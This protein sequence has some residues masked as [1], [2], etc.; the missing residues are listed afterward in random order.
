MLINAMMVAHIAHAV[1]MYH[2]RNCGD[3]HEHHGRYRIEQEAQ[4]D[5]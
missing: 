5:N 3:D 4:L 2:E 1:E